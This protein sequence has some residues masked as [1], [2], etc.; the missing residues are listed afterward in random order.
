MIL[1][2]DWLFN[3]KDYAIYETK[4]KNWFCKSTFYWKS[5]ISSQFNGPFDTLT[6]CTQSVEALIRLE[7]P[8]ENLP[9]K[10]EEV[11]TI[12]PNVIHVDFK[13]KRRMIK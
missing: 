8:T 2:V 11:P 9:I 13:A 7:S 12:I 4:P 1:H 6:Q 3:I 10:I 5:I